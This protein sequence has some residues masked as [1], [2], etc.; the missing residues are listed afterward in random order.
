[1][2]KTEIIVENVHCVRQNLWQ[3]PDIP[4]S[5]THSNW[6]LW[7]WQHWLSSASSIIRYLCT[8]LCTMPY[9]KY[10]NQIN[11]KKIG[12]IRIFRKYK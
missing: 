9:I 5:K 4:P 12:L 8:L 7:T 11:N 3:K 10:E 6:N 1:M 2:K